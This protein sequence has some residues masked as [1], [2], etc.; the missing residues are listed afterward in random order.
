MRA[1]LIGLDIHLA[2]S[3]AVSLCVRWSD[4]QVIEAETGK[5]GLRDVSDLS[6]DLIMLDMTVR[7]I[8]W[9]ELIEKLRTASD[10]F[11]MVLTTEAD[12][13][14]LVAALEA[15]A[16]DYLDSSLNGRSLVARVGAGLRRAQGFAIAGDPALRCGNLMVNPESFE[17]RVDGQVLH[18]TPTEFKVLHHLARSK[19]RVVTQQALES[20]VWGSRDQFSTDC[21]RKYI[22]RLRQKLESASNLGV[23]IVTLPRIGYKL[24]ESC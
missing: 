10:A 1:L 3:I 22:R 18:L 9:L 17:V 4:T 13:T 20:M 15:G 7:D 19:G 12:D 23:E 16:D 21:L 2:N 14:E 8:H 11:L 5:Q 6:P 24:V